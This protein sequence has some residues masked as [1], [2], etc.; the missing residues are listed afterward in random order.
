MRMKSVFL[1]FLTT[2]SSSS[3]VMADTVQLANCP[4]APD[5][6]G[7]YYNNGK[8]CIRARQES[9]RD[10]IDATCKPDWELVTNQSRAFCRTS[11]DDVK[12]NRKDS[13]PICPTDYQ[14]YGGEC[15]SKCQRGF[16]SRKGKCI[17]LADKLPNHFM[18]CPDGKHKFGAF[19]CEHD[20]CTDLIN[21]FKD[22]PIAPNSLMECSIDNIPGTFYY[23]PE[24]K[25][26][27]RQMTTLPRVW[28]RLPPDQKNCNDDQVKVWGGC[29]PSCPKDWQ[30]KKGMCQLR[31]CSISLN[32][33]KRIVLCPEGK[34]QM[35]AASI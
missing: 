9:T 12:F 21:E 25:K 18:T 14:R 4:E 29:Q 3:D 5:V 35:Q 32:N 20:Q 15:H 8:K 22:K 10:V 7:E 27:E 31:S 30:V 13:K 17:Q 11:S 1:V 16:N 28:E 23:S 19:C 33:D 2:L 24:S 34:Y 26:C 6:V